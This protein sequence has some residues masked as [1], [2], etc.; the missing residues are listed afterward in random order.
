[1]SLCD[2]VF[3]SVSN[4]FCAHELRFVDIIKPEE[5]EKEED[6]LSRGGQG[7]SLPKNKPRPQYSTQKE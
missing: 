4:L 2:I 1:M 7:Q 3:V 5:E 6:G